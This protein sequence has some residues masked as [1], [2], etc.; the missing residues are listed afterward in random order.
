MERISRSIWI[1]KEAYFFLNRECRKQRGCRPLT[2]E[3]EKKF[4]KRLEI[5]VSVKNGKYQ[6]TDNSFG[7][8]DGTYNGRWWP[9][10][11]D[12]IERMLNQ[13]GFEYEEGEEVIYI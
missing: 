9:W 2:E 4:W 3:Q 6:V 10:S 11:V 1:G 7:G 13:A 12:D 8:G 5:A